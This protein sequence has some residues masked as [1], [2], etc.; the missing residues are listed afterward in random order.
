MKFKERS[1]YI[2]VI[3]LTTYSQSQSPFIAKEC[4]TEIILQ[5]YEPFSHP[6]KRTQHT[7][8]CKTEL[9]AQGLVWWMLYSHALCSRLCRMIYMQCL[10]DGAEQELH[11]SEKATYSARS[12]ITL[13]FFFFKKESCTL[14]IYLWIFKMWFL[15][16][17]QLIH[18]ENILKLSWNLDFMAFGGCGYPLNN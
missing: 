11:R 16:E 4:S 15:S 9:P 1:I 2:F 6:P 10:Q 5:C 7:S 17:M 12:K 3:S 18:T 8:G 14:F 13:L